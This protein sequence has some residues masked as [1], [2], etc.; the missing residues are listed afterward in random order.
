[1]ITV[2]K[3]KDCGNSPKNNL[4]AN[5]FVAL[6]TQNKNLLKSYIKPNFTCINSSEQSL[7][8][9]LENQTFYNFK[10]I[11]KGTLHVLNITSHG[12]FAAANGKIQFSPKKFAYVSAFFEFNSASAK[13]LSQ[14]HLYESHNN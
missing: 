1:M 14:V 5:L 12:K 2:K 8:E 6:V 4:V 7:E 9:S 13:A 11:K 3:T 10:P